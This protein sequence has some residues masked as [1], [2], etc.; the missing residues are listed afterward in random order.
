VVFEFDLERAIRPELGGAGTRDL[1]HLVEP[2]PGE[3]NLV[4]ALIDVEA[5]LQG[6]KGDLALTVGPDNQGRR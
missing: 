2:G 1:I 3:A 6:S 4:W 5:G